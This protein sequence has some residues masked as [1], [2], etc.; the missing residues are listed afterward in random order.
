MALRRRARGHGDGDGERVVPRKD[1]T[2]MDP[3]R[4]GLIAIAVIVALSYWGFTKVNPFSNPFEFQAVFQNAN[5]VRPNSPVRIAGVD[6]GK[7]TGVARYKD[8]DMSVV[9]MTV[10]D[11]GLP[12]HKDA[13]LKVRPRIFL[14]GNWFVDLR[15]GT[16]S[17]PRIEDGDTIPMAQTANPV[18]L[19]QIL[20]SLQAGTRRDLQNALEGLGTALSR[21]PD[22][23]DDADQD[24]SVQGLTAAEALNKTY[25][26]AAEAAIGVAQVNQALL[27][28]EPGDLSKLIKSFGSVART[29]SRNEEQLKDLITNFDVTTGALASEQGNLS[30][31]IRLL[32]PTLENANAAFDSLNA[33]F[34]PTRAF[35]RDILPGVEQTAATIDAAFPWINQ[36]RRLL[37]EDQLNELLA[38]LRPTTVDT[39][40][41]TAATNELLPQ[42]NLIAK[43]LYDVVLPTGEVVVQDPPLTSGAPNYKELAY[44]LVGLAGE[45]QNFDGNGTFVRFGVGGGPNLIRTGNSKQAAEPFFGNNPLT[46]LGTRPKYPAKRPPYVSTRDCYKN[47]VPNVNG[48]AA[49][50][51]AADRVLRR[52]GPRA[53]GSYT[54]AGAAA[55]RKRGETP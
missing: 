1:R 28:T 37:D 26:T 38:E 2:G 39:A 20:T 33:A 54:K 15:P 16:P 25:D 41:V 32:A 36:V 46:P 53:L 42:Q 49:N 30:S 29:L 40:Q 35:A 52:R 18:Q 5:N 50:G 48:P 7:V 23:Q 8:S 19:D 12:I 6:V 45:S 47:P 51:G 44:S 27:G 17:A 55:A 3:F 21:E 24:A 4:A 43:C 11:E 34:P 31:T 22:A 9:T 13:E 14:E 10:D